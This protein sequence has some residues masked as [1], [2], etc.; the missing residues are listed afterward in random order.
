MLVASSLLHLL[1]T[2]IA[3]EGS[4]MSRLLLNI[5]PESQLCCEPNSLEKI[6]NIFTFLHLTVGREEIRDAG[7]ISVSSINSSLWN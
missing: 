7:T 5:V 1:L 2:Q 3:Y 4:K 6:T